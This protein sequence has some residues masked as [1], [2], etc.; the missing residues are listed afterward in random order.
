MNMQNV[1]QGDP[2]VDEATVDPIMEKITAVETALA[3]LK[4]A[5]TGGGEKEENIN[6][7]E[8]SQKIETK[9]SGFKKTLGL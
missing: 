2:V 7:Q 1:P 3:D 5:Y 6:T 9:S 4:Q 8:P